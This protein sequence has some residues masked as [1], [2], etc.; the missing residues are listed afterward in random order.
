VWNRQPHYPHSKTSRA[1]SIPLY[2]PSQGNLLRVPLL[3]C[4]GDL[5]PEPLAVAEPGKLYLPPLRRLDNTASHHDHPSPR[6]LPLVVV[7]EREELPVKP[8]RQKKSKGRLQRSGDPVETRSVRFPKQTD[9]PSLSICEDSCPVQEKAVLKAMGKPVVGPEKRVRQYRSRQSDFDPIAEKPLSCSPM[10]EE[11]SDLSQGSLFPYTENEPESADFDEFASLQENFSQELPTSLPE[12]LTPLPD[13]QLIYSQEDEGFASIPDTDLPTGQDAQFPSIYEET[14]PL[15]SLFDPNNDETCLKQAKSDSLFSM[16]NSSGQAICTSETER[17]NTLG[18]EGSLESFEAAST[19]IQA[20]LPAL[21]EISVVSKPILK[22]TKAEISLGKQVNSTRVLLLA[23]ASKDSEEPNPS[24]DVVSRLKITV[25]SELPAISLTSESNLSTAEAK[26]QL[27][28][29]S[30]VQLAGLE[31]RTARSGKKAATQPEL[32]VD[33]QGR[34]PPRSV[35]S[36]KESSNPRRLSLSSPKPSKS[37]SKSDTFDLST[38]E[39]TEPEAAHQ[40]LARLE[41]VCAVIQEQAVEESEEEDVRPAGTE[42]VRTLKVEVSRAPPRRSSTHL[43]GLMRRGSNQPDQSLEEEPVNKSDIITD[44]TEEQK[45]KPA[46]ATRRGKKRTV[47][48]V[49]MGRKPTQKKLIP[50]ADLPTVKVVILSPEQSPIHVVKAL[51]S[52]ASFSGG[53]RISPDSPFSSSFESD[54]SEEDKGRK[55]E[56]EEDRT[57]RKKANRSKGKRRSVFTKFAPKRSSVLFSDNSEC[58]SEVDS[59]CPRN[60]ADEVFIRHFALN[61]LGFMHSM[62]PKR[63]P[64]VSR[65]FTQ[66]SKVRKDILS[67]NY[68]PVSGDSHRRLSIFTKRKGG[69]RRRIRK[70]ITTSALAGLKESLESAL[71]PSEDEVDSEDSES[72]TDLQRAHFSRA[73]FEIKHLS[74]LKS[75]AL[76]LLSLMN[77]VEPEEIPATPPLTAAE[78]WELQYRDNHEVVSHTLDRLFKDSKALPITAFTSVVTSF[79][80]DP[81]ARNLT[82]DTKELETVEVDAEHYREALERR[83]FQEYSKQL[84]AQQLLHFAHSDSLCQQNSTRMNPSELTR[85]FHSLF[86]KRKHRRLMLEMRNGALPAVLHA[87]PQYTSTG[88]ALDYYES[89]VRL[90][91]KAALP[92]DVVLSGGAHLVH[93]EEERCERVYCRLKHENNLQ[94]LSKIET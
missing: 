51:V 12:Q 70:S 18:A 81:H 54:N 58:G 41:E 6:E 79:F 76:R 63:S 36:L 68:G 55:S 80:K 47:K 34:A 37:L 94:R 78:L 10:P 61:M 4:V 65:G 19:E 73:E 82:D 45:A 50:L 93:S 3:P 72:S 92:R 67:L 31:A 21:E 11:H 52:E 74:M 30:A 2:K 24:S 25:S 43:E 44:Q 87:K 86:L 29:L 91:V 77:P 7:A 57:Q 23:A 62:V 9:P 28:V 85:F 42:E 38:A 90:A 8:F 84:Y 66:L 69:N 22:P 64:A 35:K 16:E 48:P 83:K 71:N 27:T 26:K 33:G 13:L 20:V 60:L 89:R 40:E 59:G 88:L 17:G 15:P 53:G 46:K 32:A 56:L 49:G 5:L 39:P 75:L 14:P 1:A